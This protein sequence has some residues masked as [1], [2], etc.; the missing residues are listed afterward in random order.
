MHQAH[1]FDATTPQSSPAHDLNATRPPL[2]QPTNE[3]T[4]PADR[5][6]TT[7]ANPLHKRDE[8]IRSID[9]DAL[10]EHGAREREQRAREL[11]ADVLAELERLRDAVDGYSLVGTRHEILT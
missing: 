4:S 11:A 10:P 1:D 5:R 7:A 8:S 6:H 2:H 3:R 9:R